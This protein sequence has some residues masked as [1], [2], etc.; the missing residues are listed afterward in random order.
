MRISV[1]I[2]GRARFNAPDLKSDVRSNVPGV[3]IPRYPP[4]MKNPHL[5]R[6][7]YCLEFSHLIQLARVRSPAVRQNVWN[8]LYRLWRPKGQAHG[9][10]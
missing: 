5:L 8:I 4:Y 1:R 10:A 3:R 2:A 9:R 7:F 6:V